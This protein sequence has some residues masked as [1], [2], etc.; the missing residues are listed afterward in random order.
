[1]NYK[2]VSYQQLLAIFACLALALIAHVESLPLWVL[3]AVAVLS[4]FRVLL[5]YRG[6]AAPSALIRFSV[7]ALTV[8]MVFL[9]FRTFNGLSAGSALLALMAGLKLFETR[10]QRDIYI[11]TL[12]IYFLSLSAL[13]ESDSFWLLAYLIVVCW[14]TTATLLRLTST[15]PLPD[16]QRSL[17][18]AGRIFGQALPLALAFW[19]FFPRLAGPLWQ[20]PSDSGNATSG[21]S[22]SMSPGDISDL[23]QSDDVAFRVHFTGATPPPQERYF[24][25]PVLHDFDGRTWRQGRPAILNAPKLLLRGPAYRYTLSVEAHAHNWI[26]ALDWPARWDL[27]GGS[28]NSDNTLIQPGPVSRPMDVAATSYTRATQAQDALNPA[29]RHQD[30]HPPPGNPRAVQL[31]QALRNAH[32]EDLDYV[33]AV[34]EMFA[35]QAFYYTLTPP[36]LGNDSVDEFLFDTKR[37]FCGHYASAFTVLMRAAQ[38]PARVVTGY[39]GGTFNPFGDYWIVR[40]S[41]AHAWAE[42]WIAGAGWMRVDPTSVIAPSRVDHGVNEAVSADEPLA[43]RWQRQTPWL[44]Q[45][46]LRLDALRQLWRERI[47]LFDQD[48]QQHLL[49]W[50][51]V[52][53][54][55]AEKLVIVLTVVLGL[56][57]GW[58]TWQV[59]R[60]VDASPKELLLRAYARLCA[61]LAAAGVPRLPHE[62]AENYAQRIA[63]RRPDLAPVVGA[64]LRQ[65]S[66]LR[67]AAA[68]ARPTVGQFDAAVRA[69]RPSSTPPDSRGS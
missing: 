44:M 62:G 45:T 35:R 3:A 10:T 16:W 15:A 23:A 54:P 46:R 48:S 36:K 6:R 12:C 34:L 67:Y 52:P 51:N 65:Y 26:F 60:E 1:M 8:A 47:L 42:V 11:I 68:A 59:R 31:A 21:L 56:I 69:F 7:A 9:Q 4:A 25:G 22:D 24:R 53:E 5:A 20:M 17:R 2:S 30:V 37:G 18:Y 57:F 64:L 50:L 66:R 27:P 19:L 43:S 49:E 14:L 61:K 58:L 13:L 32:P 40:Q 29:V 33:H 55:D 38:I 39:Q 28:L 41:D 63:G